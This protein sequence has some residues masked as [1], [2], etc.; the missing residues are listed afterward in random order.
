LI[1]GGQMDHRIPVSDRQESDLHRDYGRV[2]ER[3]AFGFTAILMFPSLAPAL[4]FSF[5]LTGGLPLNNIAATSEGMVSTT[6]RYTI[7]PAL[8]VGLPHALSVDVEFLYKR[9]DFGFTSDPAR[10]AV[11]RL[12][13]P[14]SLRYV[15]RGS[16]VRPFVRA[17]VSLNWALPA[18]DA[19]GCAGTAPGGGFYC[20]GGETAAQLR[21]QHTYGPVLGGGVEFRLKGLHLAPELRVTRWVDRNFGTQNSPLQ[22]NLTQVELLLG[23]KF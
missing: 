17:G 12:E 3:I 16:A 13:L 15:F 2:R 1:E 20:I 8:G 11:H 7:G 6:G 19:N 14:L 10:I 5:G 18:G 4:N 21:H 22:S 23:L 9:F